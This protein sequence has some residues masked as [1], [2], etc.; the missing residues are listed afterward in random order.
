MDDMIVEVRM[1]V[2]ASIW[3]EKINLVEDLENT[4]S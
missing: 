1:S 4:G 3:E 2:V